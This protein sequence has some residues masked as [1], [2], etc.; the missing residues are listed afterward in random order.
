MAD[1]HVDAYFKSEDDAMDTQT[2]LEAAGAKDYTIEEIPQDEGGLAFPAIA[3]AGSGAGASG[4]AVGGAG[5]GAVGTA[6][7]AG[8][9]LPG[10]FGFFDDDDDIGE[11]NMLSSFVIDDD[12]YEEALNI[13]KEG[14][15]K[16][17]D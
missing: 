12:K 4:G 2:K 6:G 14:G 10:F 16:V 3:Y 13:I 7:A 11:R 9:G 8:V 15:G 1:R 5:G 17:Y